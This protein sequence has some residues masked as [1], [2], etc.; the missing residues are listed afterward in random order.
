[1]HGVGL[2]GWTLSRALS[3][4]PQG[5]Y[6]RFASAD[7]IIAPPVPEGNQKVQDK[8]QVVKMAGRGRY[9]TVAR[10]ALMW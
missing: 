3:D 7:G 2:V 9:V 6:G 1:M 10:A 8:R 5:S 4:A